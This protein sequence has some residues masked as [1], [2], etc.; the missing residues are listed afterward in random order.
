MKR[1]S[2]SYDEESVEGPE[3]KQQRIQGS[4]N[5]KHYL[6][7][8]YSRSLDHRGLKWSVDQ[9][10]RLA[11]LLKQLPTQYFYEGKFRNK[12]S[13]SIPLTLKHPDP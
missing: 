12:L 5:E 6:L 7:K 2:E 1:F 8:A 9:N 13:K 11:N 4:E 10:H 3:R